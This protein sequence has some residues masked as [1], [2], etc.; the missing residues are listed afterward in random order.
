MNDLV[1]P[2]KYASQLKNLKMNSDIDIDSWKNNYVDYNTHLENN[3]YKQK[4]AKYTNNIYRSKNALLSLRTQIIG[5]VKKNDRVLLKHMHE[6]KKLDKRYNHVTINTDKTENTDNASAQMYN[7]KEVEY[8]TS[9][10]RLVFQGFGLLI[11]S[12]VGYYVSKN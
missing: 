9:I 10:L 1:S 11:I 2:S 4:Q 3:G 6:L 5:D 12:G 8:S 7:D